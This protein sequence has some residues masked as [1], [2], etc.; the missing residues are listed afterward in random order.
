MHEIKDYLSGI[1][2]RGRRERL[3]SE[4]KGR[5]SGG[6]IQGETRPSYSWGEGR[7]KDGAMGEI[8]DGVLEGV[9]ER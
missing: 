7:I 1:H 9:D 6:I 8:M 3:H 4:R 2:S 5:R